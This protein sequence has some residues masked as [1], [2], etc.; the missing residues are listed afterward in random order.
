MLAYQVILHEQIQ[1]VVH[2]G[3]A[4]LVVFVFHA[5]V[6]RFYIK[7]PRPGIDLLQDS[8]SFRR[9]AQ[10]FALQVGGK[11]LFYFFKFMIV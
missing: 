8:V 10:A 4:N 9:F 1:C 11:D 2:R 3:P 5:D 6:K 7:M